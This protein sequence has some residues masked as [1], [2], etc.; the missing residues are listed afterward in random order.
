[1]PSVLPTVATD[2]LS[3]LHTPPVVA[4][5]KVMLLPTHSLVPPV[6]GATTGA[7]LMV[8]VLVIVPVPQMLV[9]V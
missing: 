5:L 9:T 6:I 7:G 4:S 3:L 8:S 1:M 2:V